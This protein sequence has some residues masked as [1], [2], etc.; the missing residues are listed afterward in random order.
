M[1]TP[2]GH[3]VPGAE[4]TVLGDSVAALTDSLGQ[5]VLRGFP[6][7]EHVIRV[8]RIGFRAQYLGI[9]LRA[10][11]QKEVTIALTPGVYELPELAVTARLAKPIEYAWTTKYDEFFRRKLVGLGRYIS[12]EEL[13]KKGASHTS[14]ILLGVPGVRVFFGA[15]G[16]SPDVIRFS[17]CM[18]PGDRIS[19]W[20]DGWELQTNPHDPESVGQLLERIHPLSIEMIEVYSGPARMQ[21][22]FGNSCGTIA[23]WTR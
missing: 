13:D 21:A 6:L 5:F 22:E 7:G 8:R 12:R 4:I 10:G 11:A 23:I 17:R 16:I 15:P 1:A 2:T 19:V 20:V 14:E 9:N 3:P 18:L